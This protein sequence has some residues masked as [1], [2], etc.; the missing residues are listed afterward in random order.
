MVMVAEPVM[1]SSSPELCYILGVFYGDGCAHIHKLSSGYIN[2]LV[3]LVAKDKEFIEH[4]AGCVSKIRGGRKI[5][6]QHRGKYFKIDVC[7]R[8]LYEFLKKPLIEHKST[9]EGYPTEFLKGLFDSDGSAYGGVRK[10]GYRNR[11]LQVANSD[12]ELLEYVKRLLEENFQIWHLALSKIKN[13]NCYRL[14]TGRRRNLLKF[15]EEIGFTIKRKQEKLEEGT[16][17][18]RNVMQ[19]R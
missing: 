7:S 17:G 12:L 5:Q 13:K 2:Y 14:R 15:H 8:I 4:F 1:L 10:E 19:Q 16:Y 3:T 9:I 11:E 18:V 6:I